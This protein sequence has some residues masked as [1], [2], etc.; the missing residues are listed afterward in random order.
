[1]SNAHVHPLFQPLLR[2]IAP[3]P[4][5]TDEDKKNA[6]R[7]AKKPETVMSTEARMRIIM[8]Y[9]TAQDLADFVESLP[10]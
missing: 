7:L 9:G 1:M 5:L 4:E 3:R 8:Q 2:H 10:N 6:L